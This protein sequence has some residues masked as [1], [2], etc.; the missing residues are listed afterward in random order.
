MNL[1]SLALLLSGAGFPGMERHMLEAIA[2]NRERMVSYGTLTDGRS[3]ALFQRLILSERALVPLARVMDLQAAPFVEQGI[4]VVAADFVSMDGA[5]AFDTPMEPALPMGDVEAEA[6]RALIRQLHRDSGEGLEATVEA[7]AVT[8]RALDG[9]ERDLGLVFPMSRH[10]VES[11][12]YT[13]LHGLA[14]NADS[15]GETEALVDGLVG[16]Q[17]LGLR[18]LDPVGIDRQANTFHQEGIAV[19]VN[20]LPPIP[21]EEELGRQNRSLM[22]SKGAS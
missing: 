10:L 9:L 3:D 22:Y 8:L 16:L 5:A 7:C 2:L 1:P 19:L 15:G 4:P 17:R 21:F 11:L 18:S 12:G 20:E 14:H 13:A 6:A